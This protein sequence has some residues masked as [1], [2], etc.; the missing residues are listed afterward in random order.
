MKFFKFKKVKKQYQVKPNTVGFLYRDNI[1]E[2]KMTPGFYEVLDDDNRTELFILPETFNFLIITNQEVLSKDNIALRF[3][4]YVVYTITDGEKFL[5]KFTL[6][7]PIDAIK[8]EA[9]T[10]IF[11]IVQR[12]I[13][14]IIADMDSETLN[15]K[16]NKI[17]DFKTDEMVSEVSE[18]GITIEE[19]KLRDLTFSKNVQ[20]LFSALLEA[21]IKAKTEL[22]NARTTV[23][24]AR[25]LK[26]ASEIMKDDDNM[27]FFQIMETITKI[28]A[29]GQ[30]TFM[31][32]D[33]NQL[34]R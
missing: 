5:S 14:Q 27:K 8:K 10:R 24:T 17:S 15:E 1:F 25:A 18:F 26:N 9:E 28:A 31:L 29:K 12:Y 7:K 16:R 33:I 34:M 21:K 19:A 3:S 4:F 11:H 6:D 20:N 13:R 23:A 32:G 22:E 2:Q 30:H